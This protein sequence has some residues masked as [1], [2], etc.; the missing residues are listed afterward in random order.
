MMKIRAMA[1]LCC[2]LATFSICRAETPVELSTITRGDTVFYKISNAAELYSFAAFVNQEGGE[3]VSANAILTADIVVNQLEFDDKGSLVTEGKEYMEWTPI[4]SSRLY[5]GTFDGAGHSVSGLYVNDVSKSHVGLIGSFKGVIQHVGVV[6]SYLKGKMNVGGVCGNNNGGV[7]VN[8]YNTGLVTGS[9]PRMGGVCGNNNG[10]VM[11]NCYNT[12]LVTGS[13]SYM[14]GVCG[15]NSGTITNCHNT[16][17]VTGSGSYIGG[18]CG[19]NMSGATLTNCYNTGSVTGNGNYVGGVCGDN[20]GST[21]TNCYNMGSVTGNGDYVG[22]VCGDNSGS[23]LANCYNTGT[24]NGSSKVGGV[25]GYNSESTIS[26][27]YYLE[28]LT[29]DEN[30]TAMTAEKFADGSVADSLNRD[31]VETVWMSG[32]ECPL[33]ISNYPHS[34]EFTNGFCSC[35]ACQEPT[36]TEDVYQI[37][38]VGELYWFS[39]KVSSG[40]EIVKGKLTQDI[41]VNE[42]VLGENNA[43]VDENGDYVGIAPALAWSP[44]CPWNGEKPQTVE[45]DGDGKTISGLYFN[46]TSA[47]TAGF[48]SYSAGKVTISD[49]SIVDSYVKAR[50]NVGGFVGLSVNELILENCHFSGAVSGTDVNVGGLVGVVNGLL[51]ISGCRNAANVINDGSSDGEWAGNSVGGFVGSVSECVTAQIT[52]SYNTGNVSGPMSN[53]GGLVGWL[54]SDLH[55][56]NCYCAASVK[57]GE[58]NIGAIVGCYNAGILNVENCYYDKERF[59]G[60][61]VGNNGELFGGGKSAAAFADGSVAVLL[62]KGDSIW[63][64]D[65][66]AENTLP[67]FSGAITLTID[68]ENSDFATDTFDFA[69]GYSITQS[70]SQTGSTFKGWF[71]NENFEGEPYETIEADS[72]TGNLKLYPWVALNVHT[73]TYKVDNE[74]YQ[75]DSVP[76]GYKLVAIDKPTKE[77]YTF[78]GWSELPD[79]MPD[80]NLEASGSFTIN[81]HC[82][83]YYLAG[84]QCHVDTFEYGTKPVPY[85]APDK[86][87]FIMTGWEDFPEIMPDEDVAVFGYYEIKV[88]EITYY[89][90][91][92]FYYTQSGSVGYKPAEIPEPSKTNYVFSGWDGLPDI[93]PDNDVEVYGTLTFA[94]DFDTIEKDNKTYLQ[95]ADKE[96]LY[97]FSKYVLEGGENMKANAILVNDIVINELE[98]DSTGNIIKEGKEYNECGAIGEYYSRYQGTFD[99]NNHSISGFIMSSGDYVGLF[100]YTEGA[101]IKNLGVVDSYF[102]GTEN[103]ASICG[104]SKNSVITNC[105]CAS[106]VKGNR[107][108][109]GICGY[110][111]NDTI[112]GCYNQGSI[113]GVDYSS[114]ICGNCSSSVITNCYNEGTVRSFS[115]EGYSSYVS[116]I[117]SKI[118]NGTISNCYNAGEI[119]ASGEFSTAGGVCGNSENGEISNCYNVGKISASGD[120]SM[121]SGVCGE[122]ESGKFSNCHNLGE[123]S[124]SGE[125]SMA[126]GVCGNL[127]N[128]EIS[129]CYNNGAL[130]SKGGPSLIGGICSQNIGGEIVNCYNTVSIGETYGAG[131][132]CGFNM[133]V[134]A[135]CYNTGEISG[136]SVVGS[137]CAQNMDGEILNCYYLSGNDSLALQKSASEF[138]DGS[139]ALLLHNGENGDVWGQDASAKS[140]LPD[141]SGTVTLKIDFEDSDLESVAFDYT[142]GY[143]ITQIATKTGHTFAGWY[144]NVGFAGEAVTAIEA[145]SAMGNMT[146]YPKF[147]VNR[148]E[149]AYMVDGEEYQKDTIAFAAQVTA[150]KEP[151]KEGYDFSGWSEIPATMP[152]SNVVVSGSFSIKTFSV[153]F[154]VNGSVSMTQVEY[155]QKAVFSGATPTKE[156]DSKYTYTFAGW[157]SDVEGVSLDSP[158]TSD[159]TFTAQFTANAK[160]TTSLSDNASDDVEVWGYEDAIYVDN[161]NADIYVYDLSGRLVVRVAAAGSRTVIPMDVKQIYIV[162]CGNVTKKIML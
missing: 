119:S 128:G 74:F 5:S 41:M 137:V 7:I 123:I 11:V 63:G 105:Y 50:G 57:G 158:I 97:W 140:S 72:A 61:A 109:G 84:S 157:K 114:G 139:V 103:V 100:G 92:E 121:G 39:Q 35:G 115:S 118:V 37:S 102:S 124:V 51:K 59:N 73:V 14:G 69:E 22:G 36:M 98:F 134:I 146:L 136:D 31:Q 151:A 20:S 71:D 113:E 24:V 12:G 91:G 111:E 23:T 18:V 88:H 76:F 122:F 132:M 27:C 40:A 77:G 117:C 49:L 162:K 138:A 34:H 47:T 154:V 4:G 1:L 159:V 96:D 33:L 86:E 80:T 143:S 43:N 145:D 3:N 125:F 130:N 83:Y 120:Y 85:Q 142:K 150:L 67:D 107:Y 116:G 129:N 94:H 46:D 21:L 54:D 30:A 78:S 133:G 147:V 55:V 65:A 66:S 141:F 79:T 101:T 144:D 9:G 68:F 15:R 19:A 75:V 44:I 127:E 53:I 108:V 90:N 148:Y 32:S 2:L 8:C 13:G 10:G 6:N 60:N 25:C 81:R 161:A 64:Q 42:N 38:N 93:M 99:G 26:S 87:G 126:G 28:S 29:A 160:E 82:I 16:G 95:I 149:L 131:G 135:N 155:N 106:T 17:L 62:H 112:A 110:C 70:I 52:N 156:E 56:K 45:L 153:Q 152:D 58:Y 89:L 104:Y 48:I